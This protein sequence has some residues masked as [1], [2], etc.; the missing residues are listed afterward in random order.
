MLRRTKIVATVGPATDDIAVLTEMMRA[1]LE[2]RDD[3]E[4]PVGKEPRPAQVEARAVNQGR[5][6]RASYIEQDGFEIDRGIAAQRPQPGDPSRGREPRPG[7]TEHQDAMAREVEIF[8]NAHGN[9][10]DDQMPIIRRLAIAEPKGVERR[11][12]DDVLV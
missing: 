9:P 3:D 11:G 5:A 7:V 2:T 1:G 10:G 8:D 12:G 4:G 6:V